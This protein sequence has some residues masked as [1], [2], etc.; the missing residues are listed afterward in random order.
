MNTLID[1]YRVLLASNFTLYLKTHN[2]H[3]N[4]T[5]MFFTQLHELFGDQYQELWEATDAIAENMRKLDAFAPGSMSEFRKY[6]VVDEFDS[7][8]PARD[9]IERL[10]MDHERMM[11]LIN[12]VFKLAEAEDKQDHMDFLAGRLDAHS[13]MRWFLKSLINPLDRE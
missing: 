8:Q 4:V 5:G 11:I 10:Y 3:W 13:K 9:Y 7:P 1:G 12:R 6:T 2:A